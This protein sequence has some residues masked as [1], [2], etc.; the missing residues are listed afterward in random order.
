MNKT[1]ILIG[2]TLGSI[3]GAYMPA[4]W[5]DTNMFGVASI[6]LGMVG[7]IAGIWLGVVISKRVG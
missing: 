7:G 1:L 4:L 3:A 2:A 6:L 5:G